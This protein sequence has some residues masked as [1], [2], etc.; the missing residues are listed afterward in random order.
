[1]KKIT[2][3]EFYKALA[4]S[5]GDVKTF[6]QLAANTVQIIFN[7]GHKAIFKLSRPQIIKR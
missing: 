1:M 6:R 3:E 4:I 5:D 2:L 7:D